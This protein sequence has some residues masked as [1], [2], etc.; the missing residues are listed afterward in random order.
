MSAFRVAFMKK[1]RGANGRQYDCLQDQFEL[2]SETPEAAEAV[3]I[4]RFRK[5]HGMQDWRVFA[6]RIDIKAREATL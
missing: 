3:A 1:L 6:D 2:E 4:E 5:M